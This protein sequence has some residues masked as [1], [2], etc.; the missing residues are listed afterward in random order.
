MKGYVVVVE[1]TSAGREGMKKGAKEVLPD[2]LQVLP[3]S[4][5]RGL[6]L[7]LR[8]RIWVLPEWGAT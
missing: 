5:Q 1:T 2:T 8:L 7:L 4:N 3:G 6:L